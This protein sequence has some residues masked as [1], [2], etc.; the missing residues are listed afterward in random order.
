MEYWVAVE[1]LHETLVE[2]VDT[3]EPN[4]PG[5]KGLNLADA[6]QSIYVFGEIP[7]MT[8][9]CAAVIVKWILDVGMTG[10]AI[11]GTRV[12]RSIES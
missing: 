12:A 1:P 3:S 6:L 4:R 11:V 9:S 7:A 10:T 5:T 2:D 8:Q